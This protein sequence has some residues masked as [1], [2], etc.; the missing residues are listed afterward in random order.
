MPANP[1]RPSEAMAA[2][3]ETHYDVLGVA[4]DATPGDI[5]RAY[6]RFVRQFEKDTTPPDPRREARIREAYEV[7]FDTARREEYDRSLP[8][9]APSPR[10]G[11]AA[12][13]SAAVSA[14]VV[15]ALVLGAYFLFGRYRPQ[16]FGGTPA[17]L[18]RA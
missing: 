6:Q 5:A 7:L 2:P 18:F 13:V 12:A 3:R 17:P 10:R 9:Q 16:V 14:A 11:N 4:E 8:G 15:A 1:T